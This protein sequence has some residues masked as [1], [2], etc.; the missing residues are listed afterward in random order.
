MQRGESERRRRLIPRYI[1]PLYTRIPA[2]YSR[3][4]IINL[5]ARYMRRAPPCDECARAVFPKFICRYGEA[6]TR[7]SLNFKVRARVE[8]GD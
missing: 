8:G 7:K 4:K 6:G 5:C 2:R 3:T 1:I